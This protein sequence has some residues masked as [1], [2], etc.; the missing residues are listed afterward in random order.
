MSAGS[1]PSPPPMSVNDT[2]RAATPQVWSPVSHLTTQ[3]RGE[4][5]AIIDEIDNLK[6]PGGKATDTQVREFLAKVFR[7]WDTSKPSPKANMSE[8]NLDDTTLHVAFMKAT[9]KGDLGNISYKTVDSAARPGAADGTIA[10]RSYRNQRGRHKGPGASADQPRDRAT[11]RLLGASARPR[12][13]HNGTQEP[14]DDDFFQAVYLAETSAVNLI[15]KWNVE[16]AVRNAR[17]RLA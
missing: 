8:I 12:S 10:R 6:D 7:R 3:A 15:D 14:S 17:N 13:R 16:L 1:N 4:L 2:A 11:G 5:I 9:A